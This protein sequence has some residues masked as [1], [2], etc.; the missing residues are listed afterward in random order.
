M[1]MCL[2]AR[3]G[4]GFGLHEVVL[5]ATAVPDSTA[6]AMMAVGTGAS[7]DMKLAEFPGAS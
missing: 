7:A 5:T 3:V 1:S 2:I 6:V 4:F